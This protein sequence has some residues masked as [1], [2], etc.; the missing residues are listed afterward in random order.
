MHEYMM[1]AMMAVLVF[2]VCCIRICIYSYIHIHAM[3]PWHE[4]KILIMTKIYMHAHMYM[5]TCTYA[6]THM[7][8]FFGRISTT[9]ANISRICTCTR[10]VFLSR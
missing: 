5:Y 3:L 8:C 6:H 10:D 2:L 1:Y 7:L 4:N 9:S